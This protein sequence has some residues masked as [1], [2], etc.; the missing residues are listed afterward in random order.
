MRV[1]FALAI[2][3]SV[4]AVGRSPAVASR[5]VAGAPYASLPTIQWPGMVGINGWIPTLDPAQVHD[6]ISQQVIYKVY[7]PP[8]DLL[9]GARYSPTSGLA[10][11][12]VSKNGLTYTFT[13]RKG[14]RFDNG[15]PLTAVDMQFS[16]L[17]HL[18]HD[19]ASPT[20]P[21]RLFDIVGASDYYA[22][23]TNSVPGIQ[24]VNKYVLR[25]QATKV[26]TAFPFSFAI[27]ADEI[28]DHKVLAGKP[29]TANNN[30]LTNDCSANVGAGPFKFQC[31]NN[32]NDVS[33]FYAPG[34]TPQLTLVPNKYYYGKVPNYKLHMQA[35]ADVNTAYLD[36]QAGQLDLTPLPA[37]AVAA[38][39]KKPGYFAFGG[40]LVNYLSPAVDLPPFNNV[41]CRLAVAYAIDTDKINKSVLHGTELTIHDMVPKGFL[42]YYAGKGEPAYNPKKARQELAKCPGGIHGVKLAYSAS[43]DNDLVYGGAIPSMLSAVG[44]DVTGQSVP[45]SDFVTLTT[46]PQKTTGIQL[47]ADALGI[48]AAAITCAYRMP[49]S[50]NTSDWGNARFSALCNKASTTFDLKKRA[51]LYQQAQHIC[52]QAGCWITIGQPGQFWLAKPW[53]HG[54]QGDNYYPYVVAKNY[55]WANLTVSKH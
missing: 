2:V 38:S 33:S 44:I 45:P 19:T 28:L 13:F 46:E 47:L 20:A 43:S 52:L 23:K 15:D 25:L 18:A 40:S 42:G 3:A 37:S 49:T 50:G 34:S 21:V 7:R 17:R 22:G 48:S 51:L 32:S 10:T 6:A 54:L 39:K 55:K 27:Y 53:L 36:F 11:L 29:S 5:H 4:L 8:L 9:P 1:V 30:Y 26:D 35:I 41:H 12:K 14:L 16:L 31:R 24:L